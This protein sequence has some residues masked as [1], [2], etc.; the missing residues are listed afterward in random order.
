MKAIISLKI[1]KTST[2][3]CYELLSSMKNII[4]H[5]IEVIVYRKMNRILEYKDKSLISSYHK[6]FFACYES[7]LINAS[8]INTRQILTVIYRHFSIKRN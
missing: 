1:K 5:F 7:E 6:I 4:I 2:S 3:F 8:I